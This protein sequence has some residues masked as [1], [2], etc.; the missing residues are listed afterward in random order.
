[1]SAFLVHSTSFYF[2]NSTTGCMCA[3]WVCLP[4]LSKRTSRLLHTKFKQLW[5][6]PTLCIT[7]PLGG[8]PLELQH[9]LQ[10]S[11]CRCCSVAC[12]PWQLRAILGRSCHKYH[13]CRD[14]T[15]LLSRQNS[16]FVATKVLSRQAYVCR[17]K[18]RVL[19]RQTRVKNDTCGISRQ[20]YVPVVGMSHWAS[21]WLEY[22]MQHGP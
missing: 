20:W 9:W 12:K 14:K 15:H 17:D 5:I 10:Y 6:H 22:F 8:A 19:S 3:F 16:S 7:M 4:L 1:M 13:F 2:C 18:R 11:L 21:G